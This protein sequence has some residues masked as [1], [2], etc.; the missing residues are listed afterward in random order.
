MSQLFA[1]I[2][3]H[4]ATEV[5]GGEIWGDVRVGA[6]VGVVCMRSLP[7]CVVLDGF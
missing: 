7:D 5:R 3:H 4:F 6:R 1:R 2:V